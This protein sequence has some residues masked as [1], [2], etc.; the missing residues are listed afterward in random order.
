MEELSRLAV[1]GGTI[2][3]EFANPRSLAGLAAGI[4]NPSTVVTTRKM[5]VSDEIRL[6]RYDTLRS[7]MQMLPRD[8]EVVEVHGLNVLAPWT[9][10]LQIPLVGR[11]LEALEWRARDGTILRYFGAHLLVVMRRIDDSALPGMAEVPGIGRLDAGAGPG[12]S[13]SAGTGPAKLP[14]GG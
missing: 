4:R 5:V 14:P 2:L 1:P 12:A 7:F 9:R 10:A 11:L 8:L 6:T 13:E 3:V